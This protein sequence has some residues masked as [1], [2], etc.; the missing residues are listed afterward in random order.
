MRLGP[1]GARISSLGFSR[2]CALSFFLSSWAAKRFEIH[3]FSMDR[4]ALVGR[5]ARTHALI[6]FLGVKLPLHYFPSFEKLSK[7]PAHFTLRLPESLALAL[8]WFNPSLASQSLAS[9]CGG[10]SCPATSGYGDSVA[11]GSRMELIKMTRIKKPKGCRS[12][13]LG[14][15]AA[16]SGPPASYR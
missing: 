14:N 10:K 7:Q 5:Q 4:Q 11:H 1:L 15:R 2:A 16:R 8:A 12:Q 9:R 6:F 3:G 13:A